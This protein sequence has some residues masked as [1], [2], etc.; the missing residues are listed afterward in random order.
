METT[1][2]TLR[3]TGHNYERLLEIAHKRQIDVT[4]LAEAALGEW[5]ERQFRLAQ[6]RTLMREFGNGLGKGE[7]GDTARQHDKYLYAGKGA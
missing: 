2:L 1:S 5:L 7:S 4:Q 6:A 3:L